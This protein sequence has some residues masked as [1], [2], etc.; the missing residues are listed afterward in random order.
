VAAPPLS[1]RRKL[2]YGSIVSGLFVVL[3]LGGLE[4]ALRIVGYGYSSHFARQ[5]TLPS[6]EKIWRENRWCTAPFFSPALV[7]RPLPFRLPEKKAAGTYRIFVLGSSAAMGDPEPSFSFARALETMLRAAY[8][9]QRFEVINA[10]ITAT[11]SHVL[12]GI[13]ADC[14]KLEPDLFIIYEGHNEVIGPFGPAAVFAPFLRSETATRALVWLKETRTGQWLATA[15]RATRDGH[16]LPE[17]WGGMQMFLQQQIAADDPRLDVVRAHFRENLRASLA[18]A[19]RNGAHTL[20]C[21]VVTNQRDF[22]PFLSQHRADLSAADLALWQSHFAAA[23][24]A[25][26]AKDFA[27]V[28]A[29]YRAAL[30]LD[31]RHAELVFRLGRLA[32]QAGRDAEA[33][34]LLQRAL[35]LD[36]LR[37]RTDSSLNQVI[38]D[39]A[40][41]AP[42]GSSRSPAAELVDLAQSVAARAEHGV[43]G[44]DFLYEHVHLTLRGAYEI[45]RD[46]F[47]HVASDL[48]RRG[49]VPPE[50]REPLSY[51]ETRRRLASTT[52]EQAMIAVELAARFRAPPFTTQSDNA[53]RLRTWERRTEQAMAL[54]ARSD[55]LPALRELYLLAI[56]ATPDDWILQRNAGMMLLARGA[57]AE[58][59]PLLQHAAAWID[60]DVD[61]LIALGAAQRALGHT[62]EADAVFA[63]ARVLEPRHPALPPEQKP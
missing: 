25:A 54:L 27:K 7:R 63:K 46:L 52:H 39:L 18:A 8:P 36:A 48:A 17:K 31:D 15:A 49:L 61:T 13:A 53:L 21:T 33:R 38:R 20:L 50:N 22:A 26:L 5:T 47:P 30:A 45:A 58:A 55:A 32:L 44:D 1:F 11:N 3:V 60:D 41:S 62:T 35:D 2:L 24:R 37:F 28:E 34:P 56:R 40:A 29:E 10:A 16:K 43:A 42:P 57:P 4:S 12:R 59:L 23:E 9:Q 51:D 14:A 19:Q 6:G